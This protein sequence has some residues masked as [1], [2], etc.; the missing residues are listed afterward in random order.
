MINRVKGLLH[1]LTHNEGRLSSIVHALNLRFLH[2]Y[3]ETELKS[4]HLQA[5]D[6]C[7]WNKVIFEKFLSIPFY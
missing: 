7:P 2:R 1:R 6:S 4:A 3:K 5:L